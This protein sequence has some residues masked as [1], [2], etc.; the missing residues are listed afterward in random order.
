MRASPARP[1]TPPPME[2]MTFGP[3]AVQFDRHVLRPRPWTVAQSLWAA[4]LIDDLPDGPVLELCAGVGHI[5]LLLARLAARDLVQIEADAAACGHAR[6]N[7][8]AAGLARRVE[9]RHDGMETALEA[10]E[11]FALILADP[12]W[13]PSG[14]T[15]RFPD[16]PL[17]AI[18]GGCDGLEL[19]RAC[20]EV[21]GRHLDPD[22]A[23]ILQ[24]GTRAQVAGIEEHL[25]ARPHLGLRVREVRD[26]PEVDGVLARLT[27]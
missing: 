19:A 2:T 24:L 8:R 7:A 9:V 10:D 25:T 20:V 3:L 6:A 15:V 13:V 1:V 23:S 27:R 22:G 5:G 16:D 11:R 21:T 12:P 26:V 14:E 18:D 4:E 17:T